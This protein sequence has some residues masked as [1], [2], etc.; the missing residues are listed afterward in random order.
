MKENDKI[1]VVIDGGGRGSAL[2]QK[3]SQS[4]HVKKII[5]IPGNDLMYLNRKKPVKTYQKLKTISIKEIV[6]ICKREKANL[7]DV[8]QDNAVEAGLTDKLNAQGFNVVGPT[9][10][11]GQIEWDKAWA[12]EFMK[13]Y[14][15]PSPRYKICNSKQEGIQFIKSQV[16]NRWFIK[17]A[18]LAD[19]KGALPAENKQEAFE[20]ISQM[21]KFGK[22]G[23]TFVIEEWLM[24]EEFSTFAISDGNYFQIIGSAQ[25]HKRLYNSD[26]GPN[27]GGVGCST[28]PLVVTKSIFEQA[29]LIIDKTLKGLAKENRKYKGV[30]YLGA[31]VFKGKVSVIEFN[32]RWGSPEAEVLIPGIQSDMF[33]IGMHIVRGNLRN[34]KIKTDGLARIAITGSLRPEAVKKKRKL[35]GVKE[36]LRIDGVTMFGARVAKE[37][38]YYFVS[39]GRLFHIVGE[40]KTIIQARQKAY[41]AMSLLYI[42]GNNLH[43]RTDIGWRDVERIQKHSV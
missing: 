14:K 9:R 8:A 34:F 11:S 27:T 24:G 31:I 28:P 29:K 2:V 39:A 35:F 37:S 19:G 22:A 23:K 6:K 42:E 36:A 21:S 26:K 33:K 16:S 15:I 17:A 5:A 13:K 18:G 12:R 4:P 40:G 3:Y 20:A 32:A 7:I 41:E 43:Y 25:D 38:N 1:V 30:L 10:S